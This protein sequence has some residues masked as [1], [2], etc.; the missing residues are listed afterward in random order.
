MYLNYKAS[1]ALASPRYFGWRIV[2][3]V[4]EPIR[5]NN[6]PLPETISFASVYD[7]DEGNVSD[8][9]D[10]TDVDNDDSSDDIIDHSDIEE[11]NGEDIES[12]YDSNED[13][14]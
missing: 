1:D 14:Y 3:D 5:Y 7:L 11:N 10:R 9:N 8:G 2:N 4:C 12:E 6:P 13:D